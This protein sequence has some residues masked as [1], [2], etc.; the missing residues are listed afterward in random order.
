[1]KEWKKKP[2]RKQKGPR[3]EILSRQD[4]FYFL[5]AIINV[6][7]VLMIRK[8]QQDMLDLTEIFGR[9]MMHCDDRDNHLE[10]VRSMECLPEVDKVA[11]CLIENLQVL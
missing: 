5:G 4:K 11:S 6:I 2:K 1:M 9:V 8:Q 7:G 3:N 10:L